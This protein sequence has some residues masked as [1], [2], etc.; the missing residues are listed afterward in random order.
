MCLTYLALRK[1]F[2]DNIWL[3]M[4]CTASTLM[5]NELHMD[6]HDWVEHTP[7]TENNTHLICLTYFEEPCYLTK[8]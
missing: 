5:S 6:V 3:V 8:P 7:L 2:T 4:H 1:G